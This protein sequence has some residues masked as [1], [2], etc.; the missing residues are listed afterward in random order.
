[1]PDHTP[2]CASPLVLQ[3]AST[4]DNWLYPAQ[5]HGQTTHA[6]KR[7]M[8]KQ[9]DEL[10]RAHEPRPT[11]AHFSFLK[12]SSV[13]KVF[14]QPFGPQIPS[15]SGGFTPDNW[16]AMKFLTTC[17]CAVKPRLSL[18]DQGVSQTRT[19]AGKPVVLVPRLLL[20]HAELELSD[21]CSM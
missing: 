14:P 16:S 11:E 13:W 17:I 9:H 21:K 8:S 20:M 15:I 4:H 10:C 2:W 12:A 18:Q 6:T 1:M 3:F 7:I 19:K 5:M